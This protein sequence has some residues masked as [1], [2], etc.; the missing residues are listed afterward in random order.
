MLE[1]SWAKRWGRIAV[2]IVF[3]LLTLA[4]SK[5]VQYED[6]ASSPEAYFLTAQERAEWKA[7][8]SNISRDLFK[9]RYW[10][11]RDPS[12]GSDKN[13]F[14][15]LVFGRIKIADSRFKIQNIPGSQ[16]A[17][18][19][20]FIVLGSPARVVDENAPRPL[21]DAASSRAPSS[22]SA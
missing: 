21:S 10:L 22:T 11:K 7:L 8:D 12:P 17:R 14:K 5:P 2:P 4:A 15:D 1:G 18:G 20:V 16:T 19:M 13:E 6:W 3:L 9:E